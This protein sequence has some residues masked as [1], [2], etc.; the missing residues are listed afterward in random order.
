MPLSFLVPAFL[1]GLAALA[2]PVVMHLRHRDKE[3]PFRFPSLMFLARIP[4]RTA[5]RRRI[6]DWPLLLLRALAVILVVMAFSRPVVDRAAAA[7]AA[8]E[9]R[10]VVL[11]LDQSLSMGHSAVWSAALDSARAVIGQLGGDDRVAV[12]FFDE[13][14]TIQQPLSG[15]HAAALAVLETA[16]PSARG[17]RYAA[18]LRAGRQLLIADQAP[19]GEILVVT[20]LQRSGVSGLAGLALPE[21]IVVR[22]VSVAP[23]DRGNTAITGVDVQRIPGE[24]R[25]RM[26]VAARVTTRGLDAPRMLRLDLTVNNRPAASRTLN[27]AADGAIPVSFEAVDIPSGPGR[28]TV[29]AEPDQLPADDVF[30]ALVPAEEAERIL[31]VSPG[32]AA[33][34]ETLFLER[35][36][37]IGREPAFRVERRLAGMLA[38]GILEGASLV[39]LYDVR[40]PPPPAG[41]ALAEWVRGGGGLI[42]AAGAR[43]SARPLEDEF[44]PGALRG[45]V[46]RL[47]DRGGVFGDVATDHPVF[48]PFRAASAG[49]LGAVRFLRYPRVEPA[50]GAEVLARFDDGLPAVIER[51][52][53]EGR[54]ILVAAPL[55][56]RAGDFPLQSAYLPFLRRLALHASGHAPA[57]L[58]RSTGEAWGIPATV[59]EPV[60]EA[61][62]GELIRPG[63]AE[64]AAAL[65][66][67]ETGLYRAYSGRVAG[68]PLLQ[69]MVNPPPQESDL[70]PMDPRELLLGVG[71]EATAAGFGPP[72]TMTEVEGRQRLWRTLLLVVAALL[73]L[74]TL[75]ASRGWRGAASR[76]AATPAERSTT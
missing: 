57:P 7:A 66:L 18:A 59:Q 44:L 62:S 12:V 3:Q 28:V 27:V 14:A 29:T 58:W 10:T 11:A 8:M 75:L 26:V 67:V 45:P 69:V 40:V 64:G 24:G 73:I 54:V 4:I 50:E 17:T 13:E 35:A 31:L 38:S 25:G 70:T 60:I 55:D 5:H 42:V 37:G 1:A 72:P 53:G 9:V 41:E 33:A 49:A 30:H 74:E 71:Q 16:Q 43:L 48:A 20:D 76:L 52:E 36:L 65:T 34:D 47:A 23:E 2:I 15:D 46:D 61:P 56:T 39:V 21:G 51:R 68:E 63:S 22:A 19:R 6:T 32:D